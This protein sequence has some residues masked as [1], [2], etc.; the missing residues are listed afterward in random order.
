MMHRP[1][2]RDNDPLSLLR[3][4]GAAWDFSLFV[5]L[6]LHL[7]AAGTVELLQSYEDCLLAAVL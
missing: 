6:G 2:R 4:L 3:R 7:P 1:P 5:A